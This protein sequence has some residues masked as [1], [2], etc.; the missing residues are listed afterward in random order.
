MKGIIFGLAW[1][2]YRL[3]VSVDIL[4]YEDL[5]SEATLRYYYKLGVFLRGEK[6]E[7]S[8]LSKFAFVSSLQMLSL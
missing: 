8:L 5:G 7:K 2:M 4:D 1:H 3:N 6:D